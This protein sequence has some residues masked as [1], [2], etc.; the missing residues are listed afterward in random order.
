MAPRGT[1]DR[2]SK[3]GPLLLALIIG[4]IIGYMLA[5]GTFN[6]IAAFNGLLSHIP[7]P[8]R[9]IWYEFVALVR[10]LLPV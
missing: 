7:A 8:I 6:P 3:H 5:Q 2:E 10:R 4:A 1:R 9:N